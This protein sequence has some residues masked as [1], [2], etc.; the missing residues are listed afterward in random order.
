MVAVMKQWG[1]VNRNYR[2]D[3]IQIIGNNDAELIWSKLY[4]IV[5]KH[6]AIRSL[7][8]SR[9]LSGVNIKETYSDLTQDLYL[10][11]QE[12]DRWR[13]YMEEGYTHEKV[14]HELYDIEIPNLVSRLLRKRFPESYRIA[15]RISNL[16][17]TRKEFR[18]FSRPRHLAP[19]APTV[20]G[21]FASN[22]MV[23]QI[24]GL[25]EW[26]ANKAV[27][28]QPDLL[29]RVKDVASRLR[30][31]RRAGRGSS[32]QIVISNAELTQLLIEI[33]RT[34]DS[35]AD[36]RTM[37]ALA[38]SKLAIDDS[39][40]ISMDETIEKPD[41]ESEPIK[42]N[43]VDDKPTPE[44]V[45]IEK[46][47][48]ERMNAL[49][50]QIIKNCYTEVRNKPQRFRKLVEVVWHCYFN[51]SSLSQTTVAKHLNISD[52]LVSHYRKIFD[53]VVRSYDIG[54]DECLYLNSA[55][56]KRL[57]ELMSKIQVLN[58]HLKK[59]KKLREKRACQA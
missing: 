3:W 6:S 28:Q 26:P 49:A 38:Q 12:K 11:L 53:R 36:I 48:A 22:K 7:Q 54:L 41:S 37:R 5:S 33:F 45:V 30:D 55:L 44:E 9:D 51:Q 4:H 59:P 31:T 40:I 25:A 50:D 42:I 21:S 16:L 8:A 14:E 34:I 46:E 29:D 17:M 27:K 56:D 15:R 20:N 35:P 2:E 24:Y 39:Q 19:G 1:V 18:C 58:N 57:T 23:F 10:K 52:S 32:S 43:I 13:F 47:S